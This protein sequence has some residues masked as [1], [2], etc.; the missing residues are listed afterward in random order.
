MRPTYCGYVRTN[1]DVLI[2]VE[3]CLQGI[4]RH[5]PRKVH[6]SERQ[7]LLQCGHA[8]VFEQTASGISGIP[9][10]LSWNV[11]QESDCLPVLAEHTNASE[12]DLTN[13][14]H[15][16]AMSILRKRDWSVLYRDATHHLIVY[17]SIGSSS[18]DE[19]RT[20]TTDPALYDLKPR[21]DLII[22]R[23]QKSYS[24]RRVS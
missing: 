23:I 19:N 11:D 13:A 8:F 21:E 12:Q 9:D 14:S 2:L 4:R 24:R 20:P 17:D 18:E 10:D 15:D 1:F 6:S 7:N 22:L 5:M 3:A 16:S